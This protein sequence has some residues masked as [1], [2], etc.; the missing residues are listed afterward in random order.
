L[1]F[2]HGDSHAHCLRHDKNVAEDDAGVQ[3]RIPV[4]GLQGEGAS[5]RGRLAAFKERVF[6]SDSE[7]LCVVSAQVLLTI[8]AEV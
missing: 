4:D 2:F 1:A 5:D 7:E 6:G 8:R 3:P